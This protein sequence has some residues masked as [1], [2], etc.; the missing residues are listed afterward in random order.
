MNF[1]RL[2]SSVFAAIVATILSMPCQTLADTI[3][4]TGPGFS[5]GAGGYSLVNDGELSQNIALQFTLSSSANITSVEGWI[6]EYVNT[7]NLTIGIGTSPGDMLFNGTFQSQGLFADQWEGLTGLNWSLESGTYWV[8]FIANPG[9]SGAM[10]GGAA[11]PLSSWAISFNSPN[12][13]VLPTFGLEQNAF[14]VRILGNPQSVPD[15]GVNVI[16]LGGVL[17]S[18]AGLRRRFVG[19]AYGVRRA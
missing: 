18:L 14:G 8:S 15:S 7:G 6:I 9:F 4:D 16:V 5:D 17:V 13:S 11:Q 10:P 2:P 3:V 1:I 19:R 12:W